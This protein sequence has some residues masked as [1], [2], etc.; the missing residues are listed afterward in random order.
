MLEGIERKKNEE[1]KNLYDV[2]DSGEHMRK[3]VK[4]SK[5]EQ[6]YVD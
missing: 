3:I 2:N 1:S 6:M 4:R 5:E